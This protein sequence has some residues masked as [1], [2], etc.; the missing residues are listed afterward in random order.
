MRLP[1]HCI[2]YDKLI[3]VGCISEV[4]LADGKCAYEKSKKQL[5]PTK[6][7]VVIKFLLP[8]KIN[9]ITRTKYP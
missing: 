5:P 1:P 7:K 8:R 2:V 6:I 4:E 3:L 9:K